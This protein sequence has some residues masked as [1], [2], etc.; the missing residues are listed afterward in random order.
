[1]VEYVLVTSEIDAD[2]L[3]IIYLVI[4]EENQR[5]PTVFDHIPPEDT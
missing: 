1:M 3:V 2:V 4:C 5:N